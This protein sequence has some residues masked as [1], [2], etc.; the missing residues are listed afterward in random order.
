MVGWVLGWISTSGK[1]TQFI[2]LLDI[3]LIGPL[4]IYASMDLDNL[5]IASL[6]SFFGATTMTYNLRNYL[7]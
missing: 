2:R 5:Y 3:F 4:M 6:L 7:K 1:K